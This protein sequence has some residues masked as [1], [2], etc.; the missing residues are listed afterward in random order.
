LTAPTDLESMLDA[1]ELA[2]PR[3]ASLLIGVVQ[4]L[5]T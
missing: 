3:M 1:A 5:A 4:K 2:A